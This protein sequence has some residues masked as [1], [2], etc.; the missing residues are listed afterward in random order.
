MFKKVLF[1]LVGALAAL[2]VGAAGAYF[3]AQITVPDSMI[4]AGSVAISSLPTSSPLAIEA[5][6][7]GVAAIRPMQVVN[8][9]ALACDIVVTA[10]KTSGITDF[11]NALECT[12]TCGDAPLYAGPFS[13]LRTAPVRLAPGAR[14]DLRFEVGLPSD[15]SNALASGYTKVALYVDAEQ[16]H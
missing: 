2:A 15:A 9:G 8:D 14:G 1:S 4:R 6:A 5:L 11:F 13:A 7:P 16:A 12:V 10:K 3:T